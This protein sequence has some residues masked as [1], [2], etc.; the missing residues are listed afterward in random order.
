M[1][2]SIGSTQLFIIVVVLVLIFAGIMSFTIKRSN[3]FAL[4]DKIITT[5][6]ND[7]GITDGTIDRI[8]DEVENLSY[9]QIGKC[10]PKY[11]AVKRDKSLINGG[12]DAIF[13]YK[14]IPNS[15]SVDGSTGGAPQ[16]KYY[17][18]IVFYGLDIPIINENFT[19]KMESRTKAVKY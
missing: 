6:E 1:K 8:I 11:I 16:K 2:E 13:C 12:S 3:A 9:R 10:P 18:V 7:D 17:D 4:K 19:F 5:I 15:G 14:Q